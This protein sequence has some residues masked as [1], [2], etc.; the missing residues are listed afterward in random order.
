MNCISLHTT[1]SESLADEIRQNANENIVSLWDIHRDSYEIPYTERVG[2]GTRTFK[3]EVEF[4]SF[5]REEEEASTMWMTQM[6][7]QAVSTML[8]LN[9]NILTK[10]ISPPSSY[11]CVR[12]KPPT[13]YGPEADLSRHTE[14]VHHRVETEEEKEGKKQKARWSEVRPDPR[15]RDTRSNDKAEELVLLQKNYVYYNIIVHKS[16]NTF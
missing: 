4:L 15:I 8:N 5:L 12:C 7:L 3:D 11:R 6:C 13:P 1:G 14:V 2:N 9:I 10:G 16:H